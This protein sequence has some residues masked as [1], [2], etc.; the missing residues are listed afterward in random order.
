[1]EAWRE[2]MILP[3]FFNSNSGV[4]LMA[5]KSEA[6]KSANIICQNRYKT[7]SSTE[8]PAGSQNLDSESD[9]SKY[10]QALWKMLPH[11]MFLL[12]SKYC[13]VVTYHKELQHN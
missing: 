2:R 1:M 8:S 13:S 11:L 6:W 7:L 12:L 3:V 10:Q 4:A 9:F 5:G